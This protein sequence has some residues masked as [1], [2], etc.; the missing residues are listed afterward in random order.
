MKEIFEWSRVLMN[1]LPIEF[2]LEVAF[3]A[4]IMFVLLLIFMRIAGKRG[5]KQLSIFEVVIIIGLGSA[6]GDPMLYDDV[7]LLPGITVIVVVILL[8]RLIT[9][10]T[11]KFK[12]LEHFLEGEAKC[13]VRDGEFVLDSL[14]KEN[15]AS[16]EF[17]SELRTKSVEHLGQIKY[18]YLETSGEVS[19]FYKKDEDVSYGLPIL[20]ELF[21]EST[22]E[23]KKEAYYACAFCGHTHFIKTSTHCCDRCG[24]D[25]WV[26]AIN[27]LRIA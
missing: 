17:F 21:D 12:W 5:V 9:V 11:A 27:T 22:T 13:L 18:T 19:I 6:A 15:L 7:G 23:V 2:L 16:N 24:K 10:V 25:E 4:I 14:N 20:P 8:Y 26:E 1:D 3:R